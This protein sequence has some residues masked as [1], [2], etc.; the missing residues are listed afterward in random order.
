V[1][2]RQVLGGVL[3]NLP[4]AVAV[5]AIE[6][7]PGMRLQDFVEEAQVL[8]RDLVDK[9]RSLIHEGNVQRIIIKDEHGHTF[10]EIP[11]TLSELLRLRSWRRLALFPY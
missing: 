4:P 10:I 2:G 5:E 7:A 9:V 11:V 1:L 8:G 6:G 3:R